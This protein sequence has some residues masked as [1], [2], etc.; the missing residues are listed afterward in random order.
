VLAVTVFVVTVKAAVVLPAG[1]VTL[2]GTV[3]DELLLDKVTEMPPV[4]AA[5]FKVTVPAEELPPMTKVGLSETED[6]ATAGVI[7][8]SAV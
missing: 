7:V 2:A 4:G 5:T 6:K 1:T 3:A 8:S